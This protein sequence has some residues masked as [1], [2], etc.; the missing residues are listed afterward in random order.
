VNSITKF[1]LGAGSLIAFEISGKC[2][3]Y[4]ETSHPVGKYMLECLQRATRC[5]LDN[6]KI[7]DQKSFHINFRITVANVINCDY[8]WSMRTGLIN[9]LNSHSIYHTLFVL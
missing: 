9:F 6:V 3:G 1:I 2:T 4:F 7:I 5:H 8:Q